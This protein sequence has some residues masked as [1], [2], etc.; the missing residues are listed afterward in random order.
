MSSLK[1]HAS[2]FSKHY[3]SKLQ[4]RN[5]LSFTLAELLWA[6]ITVG[7]IDI[8]DVVGYGAFSESEILYKIHYLNSN[9]VE[10]NNEICKSKL[11]A[12]SLDPSEKSG[13][14]YFLGMTFSKLISQKLFSVPWLIHL[15]KLKLNHQIKLIRKSQP[16]LVGLD[17]NYQ[18]VVVESKGRS[19]GFDR[20]ALI[21]AKHQTRQLRNISGQFPNLRFA[22]EIYF[23]SKNKM[24][25]RIDDPEE[26][27]GEGYE[28]ELSMSEYLKTYYAPFQF[29]EELHSFTIET[30]V[31][32][33]FFYLMEP[34]GISV[35][36]NQKI[37]RSDDKIEINFEEYEASV[38]IINPEYYELETSDIH[39]FP[40]G[41]AIGLKENWDKNMFYKQF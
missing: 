37:F 22:S 11:Y 17:K 9:L 19:N 12:N 23:N 8:S 27:F 34:I 13:V 41:I 39:F 29:I 38:M 31:G 26:D 21:K 24:M 36:I 6:G 18:W 10:I 5:N 25:M 16:D 20:D 30:N 14:S 3:G 40:D 33:Y 7:K 32:E 1:Y 28:F 2:N 4:G 15:E 35:G